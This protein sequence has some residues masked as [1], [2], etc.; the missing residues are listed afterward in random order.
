[1]VL[2]DDG[3]H[4]VVVAGDCHH[5][6]DPVLAEVSPAVRPVA[7]RHSATETACIDVMT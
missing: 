6:Y 1:M 5:L 4:H 3:E 7:W 2:V